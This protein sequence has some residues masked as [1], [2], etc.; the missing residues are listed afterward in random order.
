MNIKNVQI[1]LKLD[2][3]MIH[4]LHNTVIVVILDTGKIVNKGAKLMVNLLN[5]VL[6]EFCD[7]DLQNFSKW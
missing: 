3:D 6:W 4:W 1:C 7:F 5:M 2:V